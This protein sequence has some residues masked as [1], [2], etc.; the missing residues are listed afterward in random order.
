[1]KEKPGHSH[2]L[3]RDDDEHGP[4][5]SLTKRI[6]EARILTGLEKP[7]QKDTYDRTTDLDKTIKNI[8][9]VLDYRNF[10]GAVLCRLFA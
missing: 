3:S 6:Q 8:K 5:G 2:S 7:P 9:A 10:L 1:M 4:R